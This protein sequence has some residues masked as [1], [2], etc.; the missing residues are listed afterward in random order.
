MRRKSKLIT[1]AIGVV[2]ITGGGL[3]VASEG[4]AVL[5]VATGSVSRSLCSAAFVSNVD[6]GRVFREEQVPEGGMSYVAWALRYDINRTK[7]EV[8]ATIA[9]AF[10][11]RAAYRNGLGCLLVADSSAIPEA[12][13]LA[14]TS[15]RPTTE[16]LPVAY[17]HDA[18]IAR[19]IERA[20]EDP[21]PNK[22]RNTKAVVA[23]HDGRLIAEKYAPGYGPDTPIWGHSLS[24]SLTSAL[25]GVL[26]RE[27]RLSVGQPAPIAAWQQP[28]D[29]RA[30]ITPDQL[31]R[32]TSGLPFDERGGP[33]NHMTRMFFLE[34]DTA[35]YSE[36]VPL[37]ATPGTAWGYSNLGYQLLSRMVRDAA[38]GSGVE[39]EAYIREQLFAPLKMH[40][41]VI[42]TDV[43]G[44]PIGASH[45]YA[46]ARDWAKL[47]QLYLDDGVANG[48]RILP[49]G[50]VEYTTKQ[51]L[52]TG[53]GAGFWLNVKNDGVVPYW[54]AP[55][56]M[57]QLP[58]DM[59]YARGYLG[60]FI[61][62][63]PSRRLVVVRMGMTHLGVGTGVG[64]LVAEIL[65]SLPPT[66]PDQP[67]S[68]QS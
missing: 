28:G 2:A 26:V 53:Y 58:K 57:P 54:D 4:G 37:D 49:D 39:A 16:T 35:A 11:S 6:P 22:Q 7:R 56:G 29:L 38:G 51:S 42:E 12:R 59:F 68:N 63:V 20:F 17:S 30:A 1:V 50:W 13:G 36:S 24:K 23:F 67:A 44:T 9:G 65:R 32:M 46:S 62:I 10:A 15:S 40:T 45:V 19:A 18:R 41:A 66:V 34:P 60:Q 3:L 55:W 61:V 47:G 48:H 14:E 21:A 27:G 31:L 5:R 33:V 25:V 43:A 8:R 52:D 64:D